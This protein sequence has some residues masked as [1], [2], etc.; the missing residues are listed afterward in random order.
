MFGFFDK[1]FA[2]AKPPTPAPAIN[3]RSGC[4]EEI[5]S[6]EGVSIDVSGAA[7]TAATC[8]GE[9]EESTR[10]DLVAKIDGRSPHD[11]AKASDLTNSCEKK[12]A[13]KCGADFISRYRP[14]KRNLFVEGLQ[15]LLSGAAV[16]GM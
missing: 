9:D 3:T 6:T 16:I 11:T 5:S 12:K 8:R 1:A 2:S 14:T 13:N 15:G 4:S 10:V 7:D